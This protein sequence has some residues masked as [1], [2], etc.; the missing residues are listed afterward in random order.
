MNSL[1]NISIAERNMAQSTCTVSSELADLFDDIICHGRLTP[2]FQP[3]VD[4][5]KGVIIGYESLIR[6]PS[7]SPLHPP[8][9]LFE[10]AIRLN[11][12]VELELL[13]RDINIEFFSRL[14]LPGKL[15][16]NIS[17]I[18]LTQP[19]FPRGFTKQSLENHGLSC[20]RL[21][22]ELTEDFPIFD[23]GPVRESL[24]YYRNAGF[25][26]ALDDL[27]TAYAGL[28][29]W[30]EL[31]PEYVKFDK[32][33]I[34][35]IN[36][37]PHKKHLIQSLQEIAANIGCLTIA[38]GV[39]TIEEYYTVQD[40]GVTCGQGYYFGKPS[41]SPAVSLPLDML[42]KP[43]N[44]LPNNYEWGTKTVSCLVKSVPTVPS[45]ATLNEIGDLFQKYSE[46][47][48]LPVVDN[49]KPI[50]IL[51]RRHVW[52]LLASRFGRD[53]FGNK[54][55]ATLE[56]IDHHPL[57]TETNIPVEQLSQTIT[58]NISSSSKAMFEGRIFE[59]VFLVT[60]NGFYRGI[61]L[62]VDLLKQITE[63][64]IRNACHSNPL[65]LL[66]GNVPIEKKIEQY[67]AENQKFTVC[68]FDLD[69]FKPFN[70]SYG[71]S[72]GDMAIRLTST[73]LQECSHPEKDFIGHI[74]GDDFIIIFRSQNW[75]DRC[76]HIL[77]R[78][79]DEIP[80]LYDDVHRQAGGIEAQDRQGNFICYPFISLSIGATHY[81]GNKSN[82]NHHDISCQAAEAKKQAKKIR[83]NS[84][85]INR[86]DQSCGDD[87][88]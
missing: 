13:C 53:L 26:V 16:L 81:P 60:E 18:A 66:P 58:S 40:L 47:M 25:Q 73:I 29:L 11:R 32:Y 33:F 83:G 56:I 71:Y 35:S 37:D 9:V 38:E 2:N 22:I 5:E 61:G 85:F 77:D 76:Q 62:V 55:I 74:G 50:G 46:L 15:F 28:R 30:S 44:N 54:P 45:S 3:I 31:K 80:N 78:F 39:E 43:K 42:L 4:L 48:C 67:L 12:L 17:P 6:G 65:T 75:Q 69:N 79:A 82:Y 34:Q 36:C 14:K 51:H 52:D 86:R 8:R 49:E 88:H 57:I 23:V 84:L 87:N 24:E 7:D 20:D 70:D 64:Q 59:S 19:S 1:I 68:Y 72:R 10:T 41:P 63:M 27:G 21:V